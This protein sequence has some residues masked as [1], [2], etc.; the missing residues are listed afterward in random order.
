MSVA[1]LRN[2][3]ISETIL[4][5]TAAAKVQNSIKKFQRNKKID[6]VKSKVKR[7]EFACRFKIDAIRSMS[8]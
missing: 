1:Y 3:E 5:N 6:L 2:S 4:A 8:N 7:S